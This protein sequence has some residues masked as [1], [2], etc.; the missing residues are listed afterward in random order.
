MAGQTARRANGEGSI[1]Q[2]KDEKW[3]AAVVLDNGRRMTR[4]CDTQAE[5]RRK[6]KELIEF[7]DK[8]MDP[9]AATLT[10]GQF[11]LDW[12]KTK[13]LDVRDTSIAVYTALLRRIAQQIGTKRLATLRPQDVK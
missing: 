5:A 1:Y 3:L 10:V 6:L 2:R 4:T 13:E 9:D 11:L 7:R 8:R 12:L